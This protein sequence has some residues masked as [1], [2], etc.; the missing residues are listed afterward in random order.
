MPF[1][2]QHVGHV[3]VA[4][5]DEE[6]LHLSDLTVQGMDVLTALQVGFTLRDHVVDDERRA[7]PTP[8]PIPMPVAPPPTP[9]APTPP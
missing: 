7:C 5:V 6:A 1:P 8:M 4:R 3:V 9:M 2:E